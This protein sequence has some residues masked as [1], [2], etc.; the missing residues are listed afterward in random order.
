MGILGGSDIDR[1]KSEALN[2]I[3]EKMNTDLNSTVGT[4]GFKPLDDF[5]KYVYN[6]ENLYERIVG[7]ETVLF[8]S[9]SKIN[10]VSGYIA[11]VDQD[12]VV[13]AVEPNSA[14]S[15]Y[16][17]ACYSTPS[18]GQQFYYDFDTYNTNCPVKGIAC[19]PT[20][21]SVYYLG[22]MTSANLV[23]FSKSLVKQAAITVP[24]IDCSLLVDANKIHL[25]KG[26]TVR[27][28]TKSLT[29][30]E[31][32]SVDWEAYTSIEIGS[33]GFIYASGKNPNG[34]AEC[35]MRIDPDTHQM[36]HCVDGGYNEGDFRHTQI[37]S[38]SFFGEFLIVPALKKIN[39]TY[40]QGFEKR[41]CSDLS[42]IGY[43]ELDPSLGLSLDSEYNYNMR[44]SGSDGKYAY[45]TS[46]SGLYLIEVDSESLNVIISEEGNSS[47]KLSPRCV[48][49]KII[50]F[51][52]TSGQLASFN[53]KYK[54]T[55]YV[56]K[57][58]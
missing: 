32:K 42:L 30:I 31:T 16:Y 6:G 54:L 57:V 33:D 17:P 3:I 9:T 52:V 20:E 49:D 11:D 38:P 58:R 1:I 13:Y 50:S 36:T 55:G 7:L 15:N 26:N 14:G 18:M 44:S 41:K 53:K 28:Y 19:D 56:N 8:K 40:V 39:G 25:I 29:L 34:V 5:A 4:A 22:Q 48:G 12:G 37:S 35:F 23:K 51:V 24:D 45:Y 46:T 21:N 2:P 27:T 10:K 47:K 43:F